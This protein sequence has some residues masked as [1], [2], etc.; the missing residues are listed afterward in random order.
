M[1]PRW[2]IPDELQNTYFQGLHLSWEPS[3]SHS[4]KWAKTRAKVLRGQPTKIGQYWRCKKLQHPSW[5][6]DGNSR[7]L[8]NDAKYWQQKICKHNVENKDRYEQAYIDI[9]RAILWDRVNPWVIDTVSKGGTHCWFDETTKEEVPIGSGITAVDLPSGGTLLRANG[10]TIRRK[11]ILHSDGARQVWLCTRLQISL[12]FQMLEG[13]VIPFTLQEAMLCV[14][15][16]RP[17]TWV[18]YSRGW[19]YIPRS[20]VSENLTDDLTERNIMRHGGTA[21]IKPQKSHVD[22]N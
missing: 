4:K 11:N 16:R 9:V 22:Q 2:C 3:S 17:G 1:K 8:E 13:Y 6:L 18:A 15:I 19:H 10:A 20:M 7:Q 5:E 14:K 12:S 21:A